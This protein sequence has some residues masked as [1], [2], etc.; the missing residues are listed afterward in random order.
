MISSGSTSLSGQVLPSHQ[1]LWRGTHSLSL[2]SSYWL[3]PMSQ[4][5]IC[6][7]V[8][9]T[10][11]CRDP[12]MERYSL[13]SLM[14]FVFPFP[15]AAATSSRRRVCSNQ[16]DNSDCMAFLVLSEEGRQW[17]NP[18]AVTGHSSSRGRRP[19]N[20]SSWWKVFLWTKDRLPPLGRNRKS[21][22]L[23]GV[24]ARSP[25]RQVQDSKSMRLLLG[26][27]LTSSCA[28]TWAPKKLAVGVSEALGWVEGVRTLGR[29][30]G[31]WDED[32][33]GNRAILQA[34]GNRW[35]IRMADSSIPQGSQTLLEEDPSG[36]PKGKN[37]CP[38]L[39]RRGVHRVI[40]CNHYRKRD[41]T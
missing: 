3:C 8:A 10:R 9:L 18:R 33:R 5:A 25:R 24:H 31:W 16:P 7:C 17:R 28:M 6:I 39:S 22:L 40:E 14:R 37:K 2:N 41:L 15:E 23:S 27:L 4:A 32:K 21:L 29:A 30:E 38:G 36:E 26:P 13:G 1:R 19:L 35:A 20:G 11:A 34:G 12:S